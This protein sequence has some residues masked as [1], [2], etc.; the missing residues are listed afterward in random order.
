M[1]GRLVQQLSFGPNN[2]TSLKKSLNPGA[3]LAKAINNGEEINKRL[4]VR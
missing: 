1:S 4:I 2:I 3:Y